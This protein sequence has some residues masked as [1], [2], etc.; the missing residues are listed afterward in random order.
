MSQGLASQDWTSKSDP[1]AFLY[2]IDQISGVETVSAA[3]PR[4]LFEPAQA[5]FAPED[6]G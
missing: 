4:R 6:S 2:A 1:I 5:E 3:E